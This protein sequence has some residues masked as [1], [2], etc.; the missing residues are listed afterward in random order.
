MAREQAV[1]WVIYQM[2]IN[3]QPGGAKAV[4]RQSE[5]ERIELRRP[6]YHRLIQAGFTSESEA[7]RAVR[8]E[9]SMEK[10]VV[11]RV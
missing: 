5:W 11:I 3:D 7:E 6:G 2:T 10:E 9:P 8:N 4:C 1:T